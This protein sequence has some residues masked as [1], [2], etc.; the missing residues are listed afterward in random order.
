MTT[1]EMILERLGKS[2]ADFDR[3]MRELR[4]ELLSPDVKKTA[5]KVEQPIEAITAKWAREKRKREAKALAEANRIAEQN[6]K[7]KEEQERR[8]EEK[9][10]MDEFNARMSAVCERIL[11]EMH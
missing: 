5:V 2:G 7:L 4:L 1:E 6:R 10:K 11:M 3:V 9:K 8:L